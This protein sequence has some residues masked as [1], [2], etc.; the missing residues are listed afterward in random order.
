MSTL[1]SKVPVY[2]PAEVFTFAPVFVVQ[3]A[4][5]EGSGNAQ[6]NGQGVANGNYGDLL[7][8]PYN[9]GPG[10]CCGFFDPSQSLANSYKTNADGLPYLDE[11]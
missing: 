9:A 6:N 7:N 11:S 8:F 5:N 10:A 4:V 1:G 3:M 2:G